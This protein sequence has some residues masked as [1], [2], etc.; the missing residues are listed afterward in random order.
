MS[1]IHHD[2]QTFQGQAPWD[3]SFGIF[4]VAAEGIVDTNGFADFAGGWANS[5]NGAAENQFSNAPFDVVVQLVAICAEELD[6]IIVVWIVRSG[7]YDAGI[8]PKAARGVSN[9]GGGQ[10]SNKKDVDAH[11]E[12][13]RGNG[14]LE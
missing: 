6:A 12:N 14:I 4:D 8:G 13:A 5:F 10:R 3:G 9:P 11:G 7:D 1:A 2:P